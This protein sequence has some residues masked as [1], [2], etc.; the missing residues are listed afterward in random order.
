MRYRTFS[1]RVELPFYKENRNIFKY[2]ASLLLYND[3]T[4]LILR[5]SSITSIGWQLCM[6]G[7]TL[8]CVTF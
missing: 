2:N 6:K 8:L 4:N 3:Q 7:N 1:P 5:F